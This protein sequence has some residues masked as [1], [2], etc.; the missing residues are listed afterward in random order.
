MAM[1]NLKFFQHEHCMG[2]P[3]SDNDFLQRFDASS[4]FCSFEE[5]AISAYSLTLAHLDRPQG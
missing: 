1:A 5:S 4:Y 2:K 3:P